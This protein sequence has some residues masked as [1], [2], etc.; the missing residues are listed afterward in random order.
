MVSVEDLFSTGQVQAHLGLGLPRHLHQPVDIRAHH[1]GFGRHRRHL[2]ELVQL[3]GGLGQG[4]FGQA[5]GIDTLLQLF[6]FVVALLAVT[7]FFLNGLHLL[8]QIVLA[9]ATLH[10][11]LHTATDAF[12]NLQQVDFAIQQRQHVF[13]TGR[14]VD[15]FEDVLL[16]LDLQRHVGGHGVDQAAWLINA[17]EGRQDFSRNFLAQLDIL[18]ELREQAAHEHLGLTLRGF[19]FVDQ[20]HFCTQVAIHLHETLYGAALLTF[21]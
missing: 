12:L 11:L 5:S 8:I 18:L 3:G 7:E 19:D 17:V 6:D 16:L 13:D 1:G 20:R 4:V 15:D 2:L 9:L 14:Q 10:L 21:D